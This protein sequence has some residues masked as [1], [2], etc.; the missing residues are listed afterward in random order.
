VLREEGRY[1][2]QRLQERLKKEANDLKRTLD[3]KGDELIAIVK[4]TED[5]IHAQI[6][7][8]EAKVAADKA[9]RERIESARV[10]AL[11]ARLVGLSVWID[12][13]KVAGITSARI[14]AGMVLL[15]QAEIDDTWADFKDRAIAR[16]ADIL[17]VMQGL[18]QERLIA[19]VE[20]QRLEEQRAEQARIEAALAARKAE[21]DAQAAELLRREE[22]IRAAEEA[23]RKERHE[24]EAAAHRA[25]SPSPAPGDEDVAQDRDGEPA[26]D[27]GLGSGDSERGA[28]V[29]GV[30]CG[31]G[32]DSHDAAGSAGQSDETGRG[33]AAAARS[34]PAFD[35]D[36]AE[37]DLTDG[38]IYIGPVDQTDAEIEAAN[39][40]EVDPFPMPAVESDSTPAVVEQPTLKIGTIC[41]RLR[42]V[43]TAA[44][45][46]SLGQD[47]AVREK[48]AVLYRESQWPGIK[49]ALIRHIEAA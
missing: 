14:R 21:L 16:R 38:P 28:S 29:E 19:E 37:G 40:P 3:A 1:A 39:G 15:E 33:H 23:A 30:G 32:D 43:V 24:S 9:E 26:A 17:G 48:T 45:L 20:A 31:S 4:P 27:P 36:A 5:V 34:A 41:N 49:A 47:P 10:A 11:E 8:Q 44:F 35:Y 13:C 2:V 6:E 7:A 46:Q 42:F 12:R 18:Y 25:N 22:E